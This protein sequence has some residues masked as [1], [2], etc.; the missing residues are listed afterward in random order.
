[1][2]GRNFT[3]IWWCLRYI[4]PDSQVLGLIWMSTSHV[5]VCYVCLNV[6]GML[7]VWYDNFFA[8]LP[9]CLLVCYVW[10]LPLRWSSTLLMWADVRTLGIGDGNRNVAAWRTRQVLGPLWGPLPTD[11]LIYV[12]LY[13]QD[14][15]SLI[16][17]RSVY[18]WLGQVGPPFLV[19]W[20]LT[21]CICSYPKP[22][23]LWLFK[24]VMF[25]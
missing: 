1:M 15:V 25:Y 9:F 4:Y 5:G 7:S 17:L 19:I 12:F 6:N 3:T 8:S 18:F 16:V 11:S 14:L 10:T 24:Y 13:E 23:T 21:C 20:F 22:C 2:L